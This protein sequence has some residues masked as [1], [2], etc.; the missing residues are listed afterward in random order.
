MGRTMKVLA[1]GSVLALALSASATASTPEITQVVGGLN[2]PRGVEVG[3]D[4]T[5]YVVEAGT[6]GTL[7]CGDTA[8]LGKL[9][10]GPSGAIVSVTGGVATPVVEGLTSGATETGEAIGPSDLAIGDDGTIWFLIGGP[11]GG[12]AAPFRDA[13][14]DGAAAAIG[15]LYKVG[16]DGKPVAVADL[17][18]YETANNPD[19]QQPGNEQPDSNANGLA[20]GAEGAAV[21]DAGANSLLLVAP[22]GTIT[23]GAVFPVVF[24]PAPPD[25][26]AS[27]VP[28]ASPMM[29]PMDPTP[30]SVV[31]GPDGALYV[32]QLT[33]FPFPVGGASVFRVVPGEEPTVYATGFTNVMDVEFAADGTLYV[34][35]IAHDSLLAAGAGGPPMGGLWKVPAGGGTPEL[36]TA[37]GL[38][39][40]GGM[41]IAAD[42]TIYISTCAA[43]PAGMGGLVSL[44]P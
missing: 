5:V 4:G 3:L 38:P 21:A 39:M 23:V 6:G 29:I 9:C 13:V 14:P 16:A 36:V 37:E 43:C 2:S 12:E 26:T 22:D 28:G 35:E 25:P 15:Q 31:M 41:G 20:V 8:E 1:V 32:G 10:F 11:G 7:G 24:Q 27:P 42:G 34:L 18:A 19:A 30:T 44:K 17:A 40:P 33:G